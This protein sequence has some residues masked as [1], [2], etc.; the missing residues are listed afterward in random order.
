MA[1]LA[2]EQETVNGAQEA[3]VHASHPVTAARG[4]PDDMGTEA[5]TNER[6][7]KRKTAGSPPIGLLAAA[8]ILCIVSTASPVRVKAGP[9]SPT[10]SGTTAT[11]P[12]VS[13]N[14]GPKAQTAPADAGSTPSRAVKGLALTDADKQLIESYARRIGLDRD[15]EFLRRLARLRRKLLLEFTIEREVDGNI[16]VT[17]ESIARYYREHISDFTEPPRIQVRHVLTRSRELAE[18]ARARIV[19]GEDFAKVA[20]EMSIHP[21]KTK[22]GLLQ[23]FSR[24]T[25]QVEFEKAAFALKVGEL[26][27]VIQTGLG[28]HVIEKTAEK[29]AR[30][31]P[32]SEVAPEI[33]R[34]LRK[35]QRIARLKEFIETLRRSQARNAGGDPAP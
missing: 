29:P 2:P 13:Q 22:G 34:I 5:S 35:R 28:F 4:E 8:T 1:S 18:K 6:C 21:S 7:G 9:S 12:G 23:P 10:I 16:A 24:G 14:P 30:V 20:E 19:A 27:P 3:T 17:T 32:L 25:Y 15:P 31:R 26:S 11:R 33:R